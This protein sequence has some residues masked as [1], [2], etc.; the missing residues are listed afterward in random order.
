M[1]IKVFQAVRFWMASKIISK[2]ASYC[3]HRERRWSGREAPLNATGQV[4]PKT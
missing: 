2:L 3:H 4:N 1:Q